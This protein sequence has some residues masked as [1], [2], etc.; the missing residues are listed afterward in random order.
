[1]ILSPMPFSFL[2]FSDSS[3]L[4]LISS[5]ISL[6][7]TSLKFYGI[8]PFYSNAKIPT[9]T[10]N[11]RQFI[12]CMWCFFVILCIPLIAYF[13]KHILTLTQLTYHFDSPFHK[14]IRASTMLK[15]KFCSSIIFWWAHGW[16]IRFQN[17]HSFL[18]QC[19]NYICVLILLFRVPQ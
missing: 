10:N 1:M 17:H 15:P 4:F 12:T 7:V 8:Q 16:H 13:Q 18:L 14:L 11:L 2:S 5:I 6:F 19:K 9:T 3:F